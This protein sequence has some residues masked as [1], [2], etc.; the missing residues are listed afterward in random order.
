LNSFLDRVREQLRLP[1]L[2]KAKFT[3]DSPGGS[4]FLVLDVAGLRQLAA[5]GMTVGAHTLS[6]P[7]LAQQ[8]VELAWQEISGIRDILEDAL[9][10]P[11]WALAYPFGTAATVTARELLMAEQAGFG[12]AFLNAGGGFGARRDRFAMPRVHV[13]AD[14]SLAEFEAHVSGFY[15]S[16]RERMGVEEGWNSRLKA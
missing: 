13:T 9:G 2:W 15:R 5:A 10:Q 4:R 12:C 1:D 7:I 11:V 6:H 16:L 3:L 14:M 8:P